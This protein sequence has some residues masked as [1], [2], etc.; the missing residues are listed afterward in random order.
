MYL[1]IISSLFNL[2]N[3]SSSSWIKTSK[4]C[5]CIRVANCSTTLCWGS[6]SRLHL[7]STCEFTFSIWCFS[8]LEFCYK[9]LVC[10]YASLIC[11]SRGIISVAWGVL[12]LAG[13]FSIQGCFYFDWKTILGMTNC[14]STWFAFK[15]LLMAMPFST[16]S[17]SIT[18]TNYLFKLLA[19]I[20]FSIS[21]HSNS[22][23]NK[24]MH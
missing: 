14:W 9:L 5:W 10:L 17:C 15:F 12:W 8:L 16:C 24:L 23:P 6:I 20:S 18:W 4:L 22:N 21:P 2:L 19:T 3:L 11:I 1:D 13:L 7:N